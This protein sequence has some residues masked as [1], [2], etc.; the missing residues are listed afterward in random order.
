VPNQL[1]S[2]YHHFIGGTETSFGEALIE[3]RSPITGETVTQLLQGDATAVDAAVSAAT[4]AAKAWRSQKPIERGRVLLRMAEAVRKNVDRLSAIESAETGKPAW[5]AP[6]EMEGAAS[7]LEYYGGLVNIQH[8][9]VIDM[10]SDYHTYTLREPFGVVG[11]ITPWNAPMNQCARCIAPALAAGNTVVVKP[12]EYTS[13]TTVELAK[14]AKE[15]G[16][17]DGVFNV[18]LG[19]GPAAGAALVEH[20]DVRKVAFTGSTRAGR[21]IGKT[22]ADRIIPVTLELGGKSPNII[23]E[24]ADVATAVE[25]SLFAFIF[26]TGQVCS[27]GT[28]LLVHESV[29]DEVLTK[30][31]TGVG[32]FVPGENL[33]PLTTPEQYQ[34]VKEYFDIAEAEGLEKIAGGAVVEHDSGGLFVQPTIYHVKDKSSR[35][36]REEVFG[37]VLTVVSFSDDDEAVSLANNTEYGLVAGLW[38]KDVSRAHRVAA[39]IEAGQVFVND[40]VIAGVEAPFGGFKQSGIG[41]EKGIEALHHYSQLKSVIVKI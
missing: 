2:S 14:I 13:A 6:L 8:G 37:P 26:N 35:L 38:T 39:Q 16:M 25:K 20:G 30:L 3:S 31:R 4:G 23:F 15:C 29:L 1:P 28:R 7:Y 21:L 18:V 22:A 34:K 27:A 40:W 41:R 24:D 11:V 9:D 12:S 5:Q 10:G 17:P 32:E 33:G 19:N 36:Y